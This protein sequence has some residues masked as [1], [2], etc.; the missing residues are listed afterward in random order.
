MAPKNEIEH[1]IRTTLLNT[2]LCLL[3][4]LKGTIIG[5]LNNGWIECIWDNGTFNYYR[6]GAENKYDL[7]V[8]TSSS[9]DQTK[10]KEYNENA[11]KKLTVTMLNLN[12]NKKQIQFNNSNTNSK[13]HSTLGRLFTEQLK[14]NN[15]NLNRILNEIEN[16]GDKPNEVTANNKFNKKFSSTPTLSTKADK[17]NDKEKQQQILQQLGNQ[18]LTQQQNH[19]SDSAL[20]TTTN[21]EFINTTNKL[22]Q[23]QQQ[24][25]HHTLSLDTS[26]NGNSSIEHKQLETTME[27]DN[28]NDG[29]DELNDDDDEDNNAKYNDDE[30]NDSTPSMNTT[31]TIANANSNTTKID[32]LLA[33]CLSSLNSDDVDLKSLLYQINLWNV[34]NNNRDPDLDSFTQQQSNNKNAEQKVCINNFDGSDSSKANTKSMFIKNADICT[35][36]YPRFWAEKSIKIQKSNPNSWM[37]MSA[38]MVYLFF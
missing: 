24:L 13:R 8:T 37:Q 9:Y 1:L 26:L 10:L 34:V 5:D 7:R 3:L 15:K 29:G 11:L 23:Q 19:E 2:S 21:S 27:E 25:K 16:K 32:K 36:K 17:N 33:T 4:L 38:R 22:E 12:L 31:K 18:Q 20:L 30:L 35:Q 14:K 6:M 28:H